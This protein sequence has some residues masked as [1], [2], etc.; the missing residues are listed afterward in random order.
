[1]TIAESAA[2]RWAFANEEDIDPLKKTI[3]AMAQPLH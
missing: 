3:F 2:T 1:M